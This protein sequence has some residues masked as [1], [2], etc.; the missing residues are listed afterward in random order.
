MRDTPEELVQHVDLWCLA[1]KLV[2]LSRPEVQEKYDSIIAE[3]SNVRQSLQAH[4]GRRVKGQTPLWKLWHSW[5]RRASNFARQYG[6][7]LGTNYIELVAQQ[8]DMYK[9]PEIPDGLDLEDPRKRGL[10]S[11]RVDTDSYRC[12]RSSIL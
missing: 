12:R 6:D 7:E 9:L 11:F 3:A 4:T 8:M 2:L 10:A 5:F 1:S